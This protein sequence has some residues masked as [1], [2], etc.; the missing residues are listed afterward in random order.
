MF[1]HKAIKNIYTEACTLLN[2][3]AP[4]HLCDV[5]FF[6]KCFRDGFSPITKQISTLQ[7]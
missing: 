2:G 5:L 3:G 1:S 7:L 4:Y 6:S